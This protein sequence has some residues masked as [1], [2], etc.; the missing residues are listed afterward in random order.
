MA[1]VLVVIVVG[2]VVVVE[3]VVDVLGANFVE[4]GGL[5]FVVEILDNF[6]VINFFGP[7]KPF[8]LGS[9]RSFS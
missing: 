3:L 7:F 1:D 9:L 8:S 4:S 5:S 6:C 2:V